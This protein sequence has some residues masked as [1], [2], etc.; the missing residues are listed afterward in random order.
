[1][2]TVTTVLT[3]DDCGRE[4]SRV[5]G[6]TTRS[7]LDPF[8]T[9]PRGWSIATRPD[10]DSFGGMALDPNGAHVCPRCQR[11]AELASAASA[12]REL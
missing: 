11:E 3:C 2:I 12:A 6:S 10:R 4:A 5:V 8:P 1:M 7:H 9:I